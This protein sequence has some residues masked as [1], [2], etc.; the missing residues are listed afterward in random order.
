MLASGATDH[1]TLLW[2][3][4]VPRLFALA[5]KPGKLDAGARQRAWNDLAGQDAHAAYEALARLADDAPESVAFV[6]KR[7]EPV[8]APQ[9][10]Q[11][12]QWVKDLDDGRFEVRERA[13]GQLRLLGR[14][15]EPALRRAALAKPSL[16]ARLRLERLLAELGSDEI[17]LTG[18]LLRHSRAVQLLEIIGTPEARRVLQRLAAGADLAAETDMARSALLRFPEPMRP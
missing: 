15:A 3:V 14:S 16:E 10:G 18:A 17:G 8:P 6:G 5:G 2:D 11:V 7:L 13:T 9:A 4:R 1:T 12:E